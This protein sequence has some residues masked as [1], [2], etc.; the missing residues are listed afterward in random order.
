MD[1][2][3]SLD[4]IYVALIF[5]VPGYIISFF[6]AHFV[7][8]KEL[9]GY[10]YVVHLITLSCLN[11]VIFGWAIYIA[12]AWDISPEIRSIVWIFVLAAAP[13]LIGFLSGVSSKKDWLRRIYAQIGL[14]PIHVVPTSWDYHFSG[15]SQSWVLVVLKDGTQFAGYWGGKSFASSDFKERDLFIEHVFEIPDTGPWTPTTKSVLICAGEIRSI[16]FTPIERKQ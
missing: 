13:A 8:G 6:R 4:A 3:L 1:G 2:F 9:D 15:L 11:F 10:M 5:I 14:S 12:T 16:E 7:T